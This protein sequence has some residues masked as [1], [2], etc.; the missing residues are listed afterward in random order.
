[1][2]K[3]IEVK[4]LHPS[5]MDLIDLM[6][7]LPGFSSYRI[8]GFGTDSLIIPKRKIN[9]WISWLGTTF[10]QSLC[11]E[12][13]ESGQ[14]GKEISDIFRKGQKEMR[15]TLILPTELKMLTKQICELRTSLEKKL[16]FKNVSLERRGK[17]LKADVKNRPVFWSKSVLIQSTSQ[18]NVPFGGRGFF[19]KIKFK[20]NQRRFC[21]E[22]LE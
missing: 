9:Y 5:I 15:Q 8:E 22:F 4:G 16:V 3:Q 21:V 20:K 17:I 1:M 12:L 2:D 11:Y 7:T 18:Y 19:I 14:E 10:I 13:K 6:S